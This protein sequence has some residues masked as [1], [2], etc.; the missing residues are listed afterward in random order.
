MLLCTEQASIAKVA[1]L[2]NKSTEAVL[3]V[4]NGPGL[5][6]GDRKRV[7]STLELV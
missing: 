2:I 5:D 3:K 7:F 6:N 1:L 4:G